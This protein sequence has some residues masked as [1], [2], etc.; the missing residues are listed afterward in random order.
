MSV[1]E[2]AHALT[3]EETV[4]VLKT[5]CEG[6]KMEEAARRLESYGRN[7]LEEEETPKYRI[8][9]RQFKNILIYV[10]IV[11]AGITVFVGEWKEFLVITALV[12][13][14]SVIGFWQELKAESSIKALKKLTESR[15]KVLREGQVAPLPSSELV[16]G[17]LVVVSE[18]DIVTADARL[19]DD[20]G[21]MVDEATITGESVPASKDHSAVLPPEAMPYELKN[22]LLSGTTVVRGSGRGFVVA[23][24]RR[25]YIASIAEKV[26]E[27][28]P[29]SPLTKAIKSFAQRYIVLL[30]VLFIAVGASGILQGRTLIDVAYLLVAQMVSAVPEG[31]PLVVT[32]VMVVGAINLSRRRT[33]TRHLPAVETLGS[34]TVIAS[35]KTGTITE[36]RLVVKEVFAMDR[37]A[38]TL[39]ATLCNDAEDGSGDP[40]DVAL[41]RW[42]E[43]YAEIRERHPRVWDYPFDTKLRIMATVNDF[44]GGRRLFVKG[45]YEELKKM[46]VNTDGLGELEDALNR[47]AEEGLRV[48]AFATAEWDGEEEPSSWRATITGLVG[49]LD[50]PK[51]GV[52]EAVEISRRAGIRV[53]MI[54]GDHPLTARAVAKS[55]GIW[56]EGDGVLTGKDI[57]G[58]SDGELLEA[59]RRTTVLARILPENKYRVVKVLQEGGEIVAV[60]GDGVND[61]PALKAADLGIAMGSGTEAAKGVAKM[62][63]VDNNL[64]VIVSAIENGRV[65]ADNIRKV[66]YYLLSTGLY[67]IFL[68]SS[69]IFAGLP[70]PLFPIQILWINL[71]TDGV[72]D[73]TFPFAKAEGRV[74]E[75]CPRKPVKQFFDL[76]QIVRVLV[77]G[78]IMGLA[79]FVMFRHLLGIL[80]YEVAVAIVFTSVVAS[81]WINGIEA[82]K[83]REPFL[84]NLRRSLTINPYIYAGALLGL[85][86]QLFALYVV[87]DWFNAVPLTL[88]QWIYPLGMCLLAFV[89]V[90]IRKLVELHMER[91]Q[92]IK[93]GA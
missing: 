59:L 87:P 25:T 86:L 51:E 40:I 50:P 48:L 5:S 81:Q 71:V 78:S 90:E 20:S 3:V 21:L 36:G 85:L 14:N 68:L 27:A 15:V 39:G 31:L 91:R 64:K 60:S 33:L 22:M 52:R 28:S 80:P 26:K 34:A 38:L 43:G 49:F 82:Q 89:I 10:L 56:S 45:A 37:E 35:D 8:F 23:T 19:Y 47:M 83:E 69:T 70:L 18:G 11:A 93:C 77:F 32:L 88:E 79:S 7:L 53:I 54:T 12:L 1:P 44:S 24:G 2:R 29:D 42:V 46:A 67:E 17:D 84:R 66:I 30:M 63:I 55:V 73:K 6:L 13:A 57:A 62:V 92:S 16:P 9:L 76:T 74:M 58:M 65:I 4:E 75:R 72:Q 61:V 41:A